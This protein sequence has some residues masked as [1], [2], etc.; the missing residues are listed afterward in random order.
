MGDG[1]I[2]GRIERRRKWDDAE[3]AVLL[4][5]VDAAGGKVTLIARA[6]TGF[7]KACCT[8]GVRRGRQ[9]FRRY[10]MDFCRSGS[11]VRQRMIGRLRRI[12][13]SRARS[14]SIFPMVRVFASMR[15]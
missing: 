14:R 1:E 6:G 10:R 12:R 8:T 15:R 5:E 7:R 11:S 13:S 4:A 3:K 9:R 2:L